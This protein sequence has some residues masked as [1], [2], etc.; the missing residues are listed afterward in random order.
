MEKVYFAKGMGTFYG[1]FCFRP[2]KIL[3]REIEPRSSAL[4]SHGLAL[5]HPGD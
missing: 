5:S 4:Q 1:K 2:L 3:V